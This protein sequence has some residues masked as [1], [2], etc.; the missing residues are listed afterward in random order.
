MRYK[1]TIEFDVLDENLDSRLLEILAN[2]QRIAE[3]KRGTPEYGSIPFMHIIP[4]ELRN[5]DATVIEISQTEINCTNTPYQM[6]Q[7][8]EI[9]ARII[10]P[11]LDMQTI[12]RSQE[13]ADMADEP[14]NELNYIGVIS[15][16][17]QSN[18]HCQKEVI[19]NARF[20]KIY[21]NGTRFKR[22]EL[23]NPGDAH[24]ITFKALFVHPE[25]DTK[26]F[27]AD[28]NAVEKIIR[29]VSRHSGNV[30]PIYRIDLASNRPFKLK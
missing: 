4:K 18:I 24:G 19:D 11:H 12:L 22:I 25:I 13:F 16:T 28:T 10:I 21:N 20:L 26:P 15:K 14:Q 1:F 8:G 30:V 3:S 7:P 2:A 23:G 27:S 17:L 6:P 29:T 5:S 9:S